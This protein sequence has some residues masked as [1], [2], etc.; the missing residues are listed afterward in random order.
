MMHVEQVLLPVFTVKNGLLI[1]CNNIFSDLFGYESQTL[2][3]NRLQD[4]LTIESD[5]PQGH[6]DINQLFSH[7]R[8]S[9][10][11][12]RKGMLKNQHHFSLP[13]E[14]VC[15]SDANSKGTFNFFFRVIED[16]S[17]DSVT[18]LPNGWAIRS[19]ANYLLNLP[20]HLAPKLAVIIFKIDNFST[21]N[22]R[23]GYSVGDEYLIFLGKKLQ[24]TMGENDLVVRFSNAKYGILVED[25][26]QLTT[27]EFKIYITSICELLCDISASP[28][29]LENDVIVSKN[30]SIGV[31][32]VTATYKS[33]FAMEIATETAMHQSSRFSTSKFIFA[34][35]KITGKLLTK[36]WIIDEMPHAIANEHIKMH[37]QP[38]YC[39]MS[40]S[41]IGLE[42]LSRWQHQD[43]GFVSP[44]F[45]VGIAEEIGLHFE[46]D[47]FVFKQVCSQ[48]KEW[49]TNGLILPRVSINISFKTLE[50][51]AFV[52]RVKQIITDTSCPTDCIE[53]EVTET[54]SIK[55]I[56]SLFNNINE[57]KQLGIHIAIDDFGSGY[58]SLSLIRTLHQSLDKLKLDKSLIDNICNTTIDQEI[59]KQI[60]ELGKVLNIDV[61]AEGIEY[62]EQQTLLLSLGCKFGQG[63]L[64][65]KP[66]P[67]TDI[68]KYLSKKTY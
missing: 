2:C 53:I 67:A 13:V 4:I 29:L 23:H 31:C 57:V 59:V 48:I 61:L 25:Y 63:Y 66:L 37:Y 43:L 22:F 50:M 56:D 14:I 33:Y 26:N 11:V 46:F 34:T 27:E 12:K 35:S 21:L 62:V 39:L 28:I 38:Q 5:N 41:L 18:G 51:D 1:G 6:F 9:D 45:F 3:T 42:A 64:F 52:T 7:A 54:T 44:V 40:K 49:Q 24:Q 8:K 60:I 17:K 65:E 16:K 32:D 10:G 36:K 55:N 20:I 30:F 15:Q 19:R 68:V 58:S 47:L